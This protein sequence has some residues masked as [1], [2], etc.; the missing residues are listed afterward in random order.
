MASIS[1]PILRKNSQANNIQH[2]GAVLHRS[3]ENKQKQLSYLMYKVGFVNFLLSN[4]EV[5]R[6]P[7]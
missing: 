2:D 3:V 7:M 4:N 6:N 1:S 5:N